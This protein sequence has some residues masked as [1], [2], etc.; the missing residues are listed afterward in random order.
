MVASMATANLGMRQTDFVLSESVGI[1][2]GTRAA[3]GLL[4]NLMVSRSH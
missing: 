2:P 3:E 4:Q 1:L